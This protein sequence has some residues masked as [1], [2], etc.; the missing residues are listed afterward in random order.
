[1][2][3]VS[4]TTQRQVAEA[5]VGCS[6][7]MAD[8]GPLTNVERANLATLF[9]AAS[10]HHDSKKVTKTNVAIGTVLIFVS[11]LAL[12]AWIGLASTGYKLVTGLRLW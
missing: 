4:P 12:G 8:G 6:R 1:M 10:A 11:P 3:T 2:T 5:V 9:R 7:L